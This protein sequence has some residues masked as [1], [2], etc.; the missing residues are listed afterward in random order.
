MR[1]LL[2]SN[3]RKCTAL[4]AGPS[5][6][7]GITLS[8]PGLHT[9]ST[10]PASPPP[11]PSQVRVLASDPA[12]RRY[13]LSFTAEQIIIQGQPWVRLVVVG[14]SFMLHQIR[15]GCGRRS[16]I[17]TWSAYCDDTGEAFTKGYI[18][19][20]LLRRHVAYRRLTS[21]QATSLVLTT[22]MIL[23]DWTCVC[24]CRRIGVGHH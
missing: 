13:I 6:T 8:I 17:I 5:Q 16:V 14:Q 15:C 1:M 9:D 24:T 4:L 12:A 7:C 3:M 20:V 2:C 10:P 22:L 21:S 11:P 19:H 23:G 18:W